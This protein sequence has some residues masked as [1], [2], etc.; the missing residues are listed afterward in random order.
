MIKFT[1]YLVRDKHRFENSLEFD[2]RKRNCKKSLYFWTKY[3]VWD[4]NFQKPLAHTPR[5]KYPNPKSFLVR[6]PRI[7]KWENKNQKKLQIQKYF[8]Q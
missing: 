2:D 8:T 1:N 7:W 4:Y 5:E 6:N 3:K